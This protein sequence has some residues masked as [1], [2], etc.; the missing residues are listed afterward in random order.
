M[1]NKESNVNANMKLISCENLHTQL[2]LDSSPELTSHLSANC[3]SPLKL[4]VHIKAAAYHMV[5]T[6]WAL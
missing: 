6:L 1:I 3:K 2:F 5:A 4:T